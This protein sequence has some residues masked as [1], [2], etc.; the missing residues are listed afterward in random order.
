MRGYYVLGWLTV[1]STVFC[2]S[3]IVEFSRLLMEMSSIELLLR[4]FNLLFA[5]DGDHSVQ[6]HNSI[7]EQCDP[8]PFR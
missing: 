3:T 1:P 5:T 4:N 2:E 7:S 6:Y 8:D